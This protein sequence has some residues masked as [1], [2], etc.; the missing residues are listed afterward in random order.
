MTR[1]LS[2]VFVVTVIVGNTAILTVGD[3]GK[4]E[5]KVISSLPRIGNIAFSPDNRSVAIVD[6]LLKM[7]LVIFDAK[8]GK[9]TMRVRD[10]IMTGYALDFSP[11]GK[12]VATGNAWPLE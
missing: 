7:T 9:E 11:D 6:K 4:K 8:T 5:H 2:Y 1:S 10:G 3:S 12:I